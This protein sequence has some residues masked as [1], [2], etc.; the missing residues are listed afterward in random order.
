MAERGAVVEGL[1]AYRMIAGMWV[2]SGMTYRT[3]FVFTLF[4]NLVLTGMDFVGI[5]LMFSQVDSLA[6][7]SLPEVAFLYAASVTSFGLAHLA[8]G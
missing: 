4:G 1:R 7:W 3:S 8:A 5:L 6:G 2:R